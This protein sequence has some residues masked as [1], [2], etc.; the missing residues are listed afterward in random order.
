MAM[1][2]G[3]TDTPLIFEA[4]LRQMEEEWGKETGREVDGLPKQ[5]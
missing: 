1:C 2:P 3:V 4:Y 5:K